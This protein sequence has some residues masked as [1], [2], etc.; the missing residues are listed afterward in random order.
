MKIVR[1]IYCNKE[2]E[3]NEH[4]SN[5]YICESCKQQH[6]IGRQRKCSLCGEVIMY[7]SGGCKNEF[8][9]KHS[10]KQIKTLIQYFGFNKNVLGTPEVETEFYR[11][12]DILY[13]DYW[14]DNLSSTD[15]CKKYN[16][17]NVGNLTAKVF[18]YLN[19]PSKKCRETNLQHWLDGTFHSDNNFHTIQ[20]WY[21]TWNNKEFYLRS[22]YELDFAKELDEKKID[23]DVECLRIKYFDTQTNKYRCAIPDFYLPETNTIVEIKSDYTYNQQNMKDK[24]AAYK[25]LGYNCKLI[26]EHKEVEIKEIL[27]R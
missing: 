18:D 9:K 21:T 6:K 26:L 14:I 11:I 24:F 15:I 8:C 23:Y 13:K 7:K 16:Y 2:V 22:S 19:I 20:Q 5:K 25:N 27:R 12:K 3:V 10:I 17:P 1:C 4:H